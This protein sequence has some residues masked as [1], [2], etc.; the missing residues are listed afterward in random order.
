MGNLIEEQDQAS[1]PG[2]PP[3][4]VKVTGQIEA[5]SAPRNCAAALER[6]PVRRRV[7]R[8]FADDFQEVPNGK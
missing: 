1:Q 4:A 2:S 8:M 3:P 7:A 6:S 5:E